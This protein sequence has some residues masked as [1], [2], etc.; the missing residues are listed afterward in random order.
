MVV[1]M[2]LVSKQPI[3]NID[4]HI[5]VDNLAYTDTDLRGHCLHD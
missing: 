1:W 2:S 3:K 5:L 4:V